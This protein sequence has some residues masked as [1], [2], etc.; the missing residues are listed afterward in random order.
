MKKITDEERPMATH[1]GRAGDADLPA[2]CRTVV[3]TVPEQL[4]QLFYTGMSFSAARLDARAGNLRRD[5]VPKTT[6]AKVASGRHRQR[7]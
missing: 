4:G 5:G 1:F 2:E 3:S 6:L 7:F